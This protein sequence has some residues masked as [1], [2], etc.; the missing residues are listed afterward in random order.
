MKLDNNKTIIPSDNTFTH[1][2]NLKNQNNNGK[3]QPNVLKKKNK[4]YFNKA[5]KSYYN[6]PILKKNMNIH[7]QIQQYQQN[8]NL[9]INLKIVGEGIKQKIL[10]MNEDEVEAVD[11][12]EIS[13]PVFTKKFTKSIMNKYD[14]N[15]TG[16]INEDNN[17]KRKRIFF[18]TYK[19]NIE[20]P[21][22]KTQL[23]ISDEQTNNTSNNNII[24]LSVCKDEKL[25]E[26]KK[27]EKQSDKIN[28]SKNQMK[29][30]NRYRIINR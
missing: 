27:N 5:N 13:S 17:N 8:P 28:S 3:A 18:I 4:V 11:E 24:K 23:G 29:I 25:K 16:N 14:F 10:E 1:Y 15:L 6:I 9:R 22:N 7:E 20:L 21:K 12:K 2:V 26:N 30:D 19:E